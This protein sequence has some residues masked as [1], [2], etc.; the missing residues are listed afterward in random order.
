MGLEPTTS[1]QDGLA[2]TT[3]YMISWGLNPQ[4]PIKEVSSPGFEPGTLVL[5]AAVVTVEP[6]STELEDNNDELL[7]DE[8]M[9]V[10]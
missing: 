4:P 2:Y 6:R 5:R 3:Y 8:I 7:V 1:D 10:R 9:F